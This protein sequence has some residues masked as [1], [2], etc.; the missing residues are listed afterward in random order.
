MWELLLERP[1]ARGL[2]VRQG[3]FWALFFALSSLA[4]VK[5]S[6]FS[7]LYDV[8]G[9][10]SLVDALRYQVGGAW[11]LLSR[12]V[13][14]HRLSIDPGLGLGPPSSA[15]LAVGCAVLALVLAMAV[16]QARRRPLVAFGASWFLLQAFLPYVLFPRMDVVNE[17]HM[18]LASFG[19]FAAAGALWN[20]LVQRWSHRA[21]I[22]CSAAVL[23]VLA[24]A[25]ARRNLDYRSPLA[26]WES[27]V[28]ASPLNPRAHNNLG[29]CYETDGNTSEARAAYA[30]ALDLEPRFES[31]R[32]NLDRVSSA[33]PAR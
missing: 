29:L 5:T 31:A 23:G 14:V 17:R 4:I 1:R 8:L 27:T 19:V 28:R 9:S 25:T 10:R 21:I 24:V 11:Y 7:L 2:L 20:E 30:R 18:Y 6:Y 13:L 12:L 33:L 32:R 3:V 16:T 26:L 22:A 15:V